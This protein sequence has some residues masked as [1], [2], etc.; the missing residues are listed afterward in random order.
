MTS[1]PRPPSP[2][3]RGGRVNGLPLSVSER[4]LG[5]EVRPDAEL[6]AADGAAAKVDR[7]DHVR[8][9]SPLLLALLLVLVALPPRLLATDRFVTTDELF[10]I[11]RSAAF[12][13]AIETGQ[14]SQTFQ[15]GHPGVTTMWTAWLGM[16]SSLARTLAPS[17][18]EVSRREVSQSPAFLPALAS[19]RRAFGVVTALGVGLLGLLVWRLFGPWP[20]A[21]GGLLLALDPFFL[22]HARLVH[23]DASLALWMS[24]ALLA[25]LCR[26]QGG[27]WWSLGLCGV[28]TGLAL[29]SKS[30]ALLLLGLIPIAHLP[31][32]GV[33]LDRDQLRAGLRDV[34]VWVVL[35]GLTVV[36]VWPAVWAAP[37][38]TLTRFFDFVRD[39]AN[40]D[41][42]AA[43]DD[44]GAG[45]L[46]Y[47][48]ALLLRLTPLTLLGLLGLLLPPWS[49]PDARAV[50]LLLIFVVGF[51]AAM[52]MAAK[53]FDR[54][55]LPIFPVVDLLAG[56]G[57]WRIAV[58]LA[59][60]VRG[61][62]TVER[63]R[64]VAGLLASVAIVLCGGWWIASSWPYELTYANPLLGGNR[65]AHRTIASGWGEGLDE[66][67]RYLNEHAS[68]GR[69]RA[70]MPGEIYTTVL[71]AQLDGT[72]APAEGFDAGAYDALVVYLRNV[73]LGERPP[74]FDEELLAWA[75][76]Q[77]VVLNGVPYAWVYSTR[78]GAPVGAVFGDL[79]ALD[80]YGLDTALP[81]I[82]R[83][84]E[85][86][87]RWRPLH[88]LPEGLG[89]VVELRP[90]SGG[91]PS[92]L[93]LPL[94]PTGTSGEPSAWAA[95]ERTSVTYQLPLDPGMAADAYVLAVRVVGADGEP[96][97]LTRQPLRPPGV[98]SEPDAVPL[99][100]IQAR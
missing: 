44:L 11:G 94:E 14:L 8:R 76:E 71:D 99:R 31:W 36:L 65:V 61:A 97:P 72:V 3:R 82:G 50:P 10:W 81:R 100:R 91:R 12:V 52:T 53:G 54:Y 84:L 38:E 64:A 21:L 66:A 48:L 92:T 46:F 89:V 7:A 80:G 74:F 13:R 41:H 68:G 93:T 2:A 29:L 86:R 42:A 27:G 25:A 33:R 37:G 67:A 58:R 95:E 18:R 6:A 9:Y 70:A 69:M 77:T 73:Q 20:A 39:N 55:L 88:P 26:W 78:A 62:G 4:G 23:V 30:P 79:L 16:G 57:L 40:P 90:S 19:A 63:R 32:R 15:T 75:P 59:D 28:S 24:L 83:R 17:R 35:T 43:A 5:G 96:V 56:L 1:P 47:P 87:L 22:A 60:L 49:R 45:A 85:L 51:G 34:G 98:P